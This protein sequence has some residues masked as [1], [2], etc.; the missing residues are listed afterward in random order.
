MHSF[1]LLTKRCFCPSLNFAIARN[2][3]SVLVL[4]FEGCCNAFESLAGVV[5]VALAL[6]LAL[7]QEPEFLLVV[8]GGIS[9]S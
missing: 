8:V 5:A 7:A 6:A 3:F 9:L 4:V 1:N 2:S